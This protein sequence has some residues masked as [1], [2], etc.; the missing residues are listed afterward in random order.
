MGFETVKLDWAGDQV[1]LLRDRNDFP[2]VMTQPHGANGADLL[3]LSVIGCSAWDIVG[4]L[5]K[6]RQQL[7]GV[8][9]IANSEQEEDPPWRF[10]SIHIVYRF[11]GRNLDAGQVRLAIELTET[12]YCSTYATLRE[13]VGITSLFEIVEEQVTALPATDNAQNR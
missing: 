8:Q 10:K 6:Q 1:F 9:V 7:T 13:V 4:I 3:P 12:K 2:I 5:R 11:T